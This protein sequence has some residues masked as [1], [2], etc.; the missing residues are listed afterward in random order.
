MKS[1]G[2]HGLAFPETPDEAKEWETEPQPR[3][4][5]KSALATKVLCVAHTRI[6]GAWSAF[7]DA[8]PGINHSN[9]MEAVFRHGTK[10]PEEIARLLF[11]LFEGVPYA[12]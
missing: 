7:I 6:E 5:Q 9:E 8:V 4:E 11:P 12:G 3:Y 1:I 2:K 10:L